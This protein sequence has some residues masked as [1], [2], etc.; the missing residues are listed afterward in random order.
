MVKPAAAFGPF[1]SST[2]LSWAEAPS[3]SD[4]SQPLLSL[5]PSS[6]ANRNQ[7]LVAGV[8]TGSPS[9]PQNRL[10]TFT[11]RVNPCFD[12]ICTFKGNKRLSGHLH[13]KRKLPSWRSPELLPSV[14]SHHGCSAAA[15]L[16]LPTNTSAPRALLRLRRPQPLFQHQVLPRKETP[17]LPTAQAEQHRHPVPP[18]V[19]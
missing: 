17:A 8:V 9:R 18:R 7:V 1:S 19:D 13:P 14:Q 4:T 16:L 3:V 15:P 10:P 6:L 2:S 5:G 11:V 12:Q